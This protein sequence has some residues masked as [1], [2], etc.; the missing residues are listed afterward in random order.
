VLYWVL[1]K[2]DLFNSCDAAALSFTLSGSGLDLLTMLSANCENPAVKEKK[3]YQNQKRGIPY[4]KA[5][6]HLLSFEK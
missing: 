2:V 3:K 1:F 4:I 6:F 5:V